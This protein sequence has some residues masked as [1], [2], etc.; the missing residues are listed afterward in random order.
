M[1]PERCALQ[2]RMAYRQVTG[3][4]RVPSFDRIHAIHAALVRA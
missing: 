1:A 2:M 3:P 4:A